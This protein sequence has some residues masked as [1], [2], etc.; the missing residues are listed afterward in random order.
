MGRLINEVGNVYGRLTVIK[1][2]GRNGAGGVL[3]Q[4]KCICG[5]IKVTDG[6][7]LRS[8]A[9]KSCGCFQKDRVRETIMLPNGHAAFNGLYSQYKYFAKKRELVFELTKEDFSFITKMNCFYC[10]K[11]PAQKAGKTDLNGFY[12]YNGIDRIDNKKGYTIN[13]VVPCCGH[14]NMAKGNMTIE[15]FRSH[16]LAIT[17][18]REW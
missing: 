8:G 18:H 10:G 14:C 7:R 3:W 6:Y 12:I 9:T 15:E 1:E 17:K 16:V 2:V 5:N 4:C 13:N 11:E